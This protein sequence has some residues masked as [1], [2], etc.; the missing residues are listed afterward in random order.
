MIPSEHM[1]TKV[2]QSRMFE[3]VIQ[4]VEDAIVRGNLQPGDRL[5]AERELQKMLD[6][7]RGHLDGNPC[8]FWSKRD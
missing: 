3:D 8:V 7:S 1:F 6:V 2:R 5:P 4:Q